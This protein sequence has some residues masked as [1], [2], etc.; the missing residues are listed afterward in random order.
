MKSETEMEK[1]HDQLTKEIK[2]I[3]EAI[4]VHEARLNMRAKAI[5][6]ELNLNSRLFAVEE[7]L[8]QI[9]EYLRRQAK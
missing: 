6:E 9:D 7:K 4:A 1:E 5:G 3:R 8:N 2:S